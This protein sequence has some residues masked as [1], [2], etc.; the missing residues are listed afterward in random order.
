MHADVGRI[1]VTQPLRQIEAAARVGPI[2]DAAHVEHRV[3]GVDGREG[4][5]DLG[6]LLAKQGGGFLGENVGMDVD[7][8]RRAHFAL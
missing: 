6:C 1:H 8:A 4:D 3:V 7:A 5:R 2:G